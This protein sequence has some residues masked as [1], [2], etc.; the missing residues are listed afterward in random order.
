MGPSGGG[1]DPPQYFFVPQPGS[2][3]SAKSKMNYT[4]KHTQEAVET[5][6]NEAVHWEP[7]PQLTRDL[8]TWILQHPADRAVLFNETMDE[9]IQGKPHSRCKKD[10]NA[11]IAE[12]IF[13]HDRQYGESYAAHPAKFATAVASRLATLKN[14]YRQHASRFKSTGEG[15]SPDDP[16]HRNLHEKVLAEFPFWD[17]CDQLWH[18]NPA[19]NARVFNATPGTNRTVDFLS[20]VKHGGTTSVPA[21]G[22]SQVRG[23]DDTMA[24]D[25]NYTCPPLDFSPVAERDSFGDELEQ[26]DEEG[27]EEEEEE[28][29]ERTDEGQGWGQAMS[30]FPANPMLVDEPPWILDDHVTSHYP[31]NSTDTFLP[32]D[33][34][35]GSAKRQ[36]PSWDSCSAFRKVPYPKSPL[37][38]I[39][40][41][42]S[43]TSS[44]G[45]QHLAKTSKTS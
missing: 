7:Y 30:E 20:V 18:S 10:I 42:T 19:Y 29:E 32:L 5:S 11:V 1:R 44:S 39:S 4:K 8:L 34:S 27:E 17:E 16:N 38:I 36:T 6:G 12:T 21:S 41:S 45:L 26:E 28:E 25:L 43:T 14:K 9:K 37:S 24:K 35:I 31:G 13:R 15:I 3:I 23:Q 22:S 40:T 2:Q 33:T